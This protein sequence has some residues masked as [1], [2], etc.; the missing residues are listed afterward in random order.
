MNRPDIIEKTTDFGEKYYY[1]RHKS[2]L[3]VY[4]IPKDF[5]TSF[6]MFSTY[7]SNDAALR[8]RDLTG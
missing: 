8:C 1:A 4:V 5:K 2:G 6:A 3:D 7:L